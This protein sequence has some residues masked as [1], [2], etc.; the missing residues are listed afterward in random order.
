MSSRPRP[1]STLIT[2]LFD[3]DDTLIDSFDARAHALQWTFS[4]AG[5]HRLTAV[6]F[7]RSLHGS[8]LI[9]SL[10]QL[11]VEHKIEGG[12]IETYR[13][14]YWSKEPGLIGLFPGVRRMLSELVSHGVRLGLVTQKTLMFELEGRQVGALQEL[15]ELDIHDLFEVVVGS[16]DVTNSKPDPEG[17]NLALAK[18]SSSHYDTLMVG[19]SSADIEA[20]RSAGC[21]S[22]H[23]TWGLPV[24]AHRLPGAQADFVAD[25][26]EALAALLFESF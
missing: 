20:A 3:L 5:F 6:E 22:C 11:E 15:S 24:T 16:E 9:T 1:T 13:R 25:T 2:V 4:R 18:L 14:A 26:P 23:A 8:Q 21:W 19:D 10:A 12:L 17:I 7:L